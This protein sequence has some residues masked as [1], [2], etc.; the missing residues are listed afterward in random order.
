MNHSDKYLV[1]SY[2]L[3][4]FYFLNENSAGIK[5]DFFFCNLKCN[6]HMNLICK[7]CKNCSFCII[8][9]CQWGINDDLVWKQISLS[10]T[11]PEYSQHTLENS[12]AARWKQNLL[13]R[14]KRRLTLHVWTAGELVG[15][16][17]GSCPW[18][19]SVLWAIQSVLH[20]N[21][22]EADP[23]VIIVPLRDEWL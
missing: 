22:L 12:H 23:V 4:M 7:V 10:W 11:Y 14:H 5:I 15:L 20:S 1:F 19:V 21:T 13:K 9:C 18:R 17:W 8:Y 2:F 3:Y 6:C 16:Y